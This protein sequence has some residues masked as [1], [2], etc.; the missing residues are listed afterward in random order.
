MSTPAVPAALPAAA[1]PTP[2]APAGALPAPAPTAASPGT[3]PAGAPAARRARTPRPTPPPGEAPPAEPPRARTGLLRRLGIVGMDRLEAPVLASLATRAPLLLIGPHGTAKTLLLTRIADALGLTFRHYNA[4][5]LNFDDL[6]GYPLPGKDGSLEYVRTPASIWGAGAVLFD[7]VSRCRP[8]MQNKLFPLVHERRVQGIALEGLEHRWAA[9]NPPPGDD[10]EEG[11]AG[12]EPLDPALAD[13]FAFVLLMPAWQAFTTEE[14]LALV[15]SGEAQRDPQA[16]PALVHAVERTRHL[17]AAQGEAFRQGVARYVE[18]VAVL[19]SQSGIELS[20]RRMVMLYEAVASVTA[21]AQALDASAS[22][23]E[24]ALVA[25]RASLPQRAEG[26]IVSEAKVLAAHREALD[27]A[28]LG[29]GDALEVI[30]RTLDPLDRLCATLA[31]TS[32]G[33][34]E[35][36]RITADVLAMLPHGAREAA[37]VRLFDTG[38]VG[39]LHAAVAAQAGETYVHLAQR[40]RIDTRAVPSHPRYKAWQWLVTQLAQLDPQDPQSH[41]LANTLCHLFTTR[42]VETAEELERA[43]QAYVLA[44]ARLRSA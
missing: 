40:Q 10:D 4:S 26:R 37:I 38:A 12:C 5:L 31:A 1:V 28:Q 20:A 32:L 11:Y 8:D 44:Y 27:M 2:P 41:L 19:L 17:L 15:R 14:R 22:P 39:R 7:E 16:G 33:R 6:V 34:D 18:A 43:A 9:M 3:G 24:A 29:T 42:G 23:D 35:F 30:L 25:L 36:S 21:A 13:R